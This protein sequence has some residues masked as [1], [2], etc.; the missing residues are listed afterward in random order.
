MAAAGMENVIVVGFDAAVLRIGGCFSFAHKTSD[1][2]DIIFFADI[3][4]ILL[5]NS[6][7][8]F[9]MEGNHAEESNSFC[10]I[11]RGVIN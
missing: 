2:A 9:Q 11:N 7:P 8:I 10:K 4:K 1:F 5:I 3:V 6:N